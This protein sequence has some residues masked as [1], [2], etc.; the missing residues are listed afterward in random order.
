[1]VISEVFSFCITILPSVLLHTFLLPQPHSTPVFVLS[2]HSDHQALLCS[3]SLHHSPENASRVIRGIT[4]CLFFQE[5]KSCITCC[6]KSE[7]IFL[8]NF[9]LQESMSCISLSCS[10]SEEYMN[11]FYYK[12]NFLIEIGLLRFSIYLHCSFDKSSFLSS[13]FIF[14]FFLNCSSESLVFIC[15]CQ[16]L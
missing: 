1:M 15:C 9:S 12:I 10:A 11:I 2:T 13:I 16:N 14:D 8:S 7:I 4:L 6:A 5:S 3:L